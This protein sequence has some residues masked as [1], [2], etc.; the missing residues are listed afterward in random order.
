MGKYYAIFKRKDPEF[1]KE[2]K[3][4]LIKINKYLTEQANDPKYHASRTRGKSKAKNLTI[5]EDEWEFV[6]KQQHENP[7]L[8]DE[9]TVYYNDTLIWNMKRT[10]TLRDS[11]NLN[12]DA[13]MDS[14]Q[15]CLREVSENFDRD[16]PWCGPRY[17]TDGRGL[18]YEVLYFGNDE[19]FEL[20]E[21][22][23]DGLEDPLWSAICKGGF[24]K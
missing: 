2:F 19:E 14:V 1:V 7:P 13:A 8:T 5:K 21:T 18:H 16:R 11:E 22:I 15:H 9:A 24:T 10:S 20:I 3:Q 23:R 12:R 4:L 6:G 17:Y